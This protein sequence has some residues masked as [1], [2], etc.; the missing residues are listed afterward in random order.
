MADKTNISTTGCI[1]AIL[2]L[3][4]SILLRGW[5]LT[6]LWEWFVVPGFG[7]EPISIPIAYGLALVVTLLNPTLSEHDSRDIWEAVIFS[8]LMPL[9]FLAI[10]WV[11]AQ[12]V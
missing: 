8:I 11:V 7:L 10:G 6:K 3:P 5:V 2:V 4:I 12:W 9:F 1:A